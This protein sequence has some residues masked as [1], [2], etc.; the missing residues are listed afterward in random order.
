MLASIHLAVRK[1]T[2][3]GHYFMQPI[4]IIKT[5]QTISFHLYT[6]LTILSYC[7][8]VVFTDKEMRVTKRLHDLPELG[9]L[10]CGQ[11]SMAELY[12]LASSPAA[13]HVSTQKASFLS[14]RWGPVLMLGVSAPLMDTVSQT[15]MVKT[16][17]IR[18]PSASLQSPP[19]IAKMDVLQ[20]K[21][22]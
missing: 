11:G 20:L 18:E 9:G 8:C 15:Q 5:A 17:M 12:L 3:W 10:C 1:G 7:V 22:T 4:I 21:C 14:Q 13:F 2:K 6:N 19:F 16:A